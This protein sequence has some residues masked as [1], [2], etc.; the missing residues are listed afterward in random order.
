MLLAVSVVSV[1]LL[2][3]TTMTD[4]PEPEAPSIADMSM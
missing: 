1:L 2:T 3:E 4:L